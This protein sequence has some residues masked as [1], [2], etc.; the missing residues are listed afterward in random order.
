MARIDRAAEP[1]NL[2]SDAVDVLASVGVPAA[3][4]GM[5][6]LAGA[7]LLS[8]VTVDGADYYHL[9]RD[10]VDFAGAYLVRRGD[11]EVWHVSVDG[12]ETVFVNST[13][14]LFLVFLER[15]LGFLE[16]FRAVDDKQ[17]IRHGKKLRKELRKLDPRAFRGDE[18]WWGFVFEEVADGIR[19]PGD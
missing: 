14:P 1:V 12:S 19:L 3:I 6:H 7:P 16:D 4:E 11:G 2:P 8:G 13:V 9:G 17:A 15:W 18:T 10:E 5:F